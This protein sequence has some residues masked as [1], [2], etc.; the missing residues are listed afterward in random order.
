MS[1]QIRPPHFA[2]P[3]R[4]RST[5]PA[6]R[7]A[8]LSALLDPESQPSVVPLSATAASVNPRHSNGQK[9]VQS[10]TRLRGIQTSIPS[11]LPYRLSALAPA[12][13][14]YV[15]ST[16]FQPAKNS[17]P[18]SPEPFLK[19]AAALS[20]TSS[21]LLWIGRSQ[22]SAQWHSPRHGGAHPD[23]RSCFYPVTATSSRGSSRIGFSI[24]RTSRSQGGVFSDAHPSNSLSTPAAGLFTIP[25]LLAITI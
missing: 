5:N 12:H 15:L 10:S 9:I 6:G 17:E 13:L 4:S 16:F 21:R 24:Q 18:P 22:R 20:W 23:A 14:G 25:P 2:H 8:S 19:G 1:R 3:S 11:P 7:S